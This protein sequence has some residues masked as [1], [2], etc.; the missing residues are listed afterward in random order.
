MR[1]GWMTV[2]LLFFC[3]KAA[4]EADEEIDKF[5]VSRHPLLMCSGYVIKCAMICPFPTVSDERAYGVLHRLRRH[6]KP[7][8]CLRV[9]TLG[10]VTVLVRGGQNCVNNV[11]HIVVA[12]KS[13][14]CSKAAQ[15]FL[16]TAA[17]N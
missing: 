11:Y 12:D 5:P 16:N 2:L 15:E 3:F 9:H 10:K 6:P 4:N 14:C 8:C 13:G 17:W 1:F 7:F